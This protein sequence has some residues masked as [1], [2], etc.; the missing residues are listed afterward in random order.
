[1]SRKSN[2]FLLV[3]RGKHDFVPAI[4]SELSGSLNHSLVMQGSLPF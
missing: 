1:M 4:K 2:M 3:S